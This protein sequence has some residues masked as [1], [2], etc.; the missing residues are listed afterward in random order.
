MYLPN[1]GQKV[2]FA[3]WHNGTIT[4]FVTKHVLILCSKIVRNNILRHKKQP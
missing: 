4:T 2:L 3:M 1:D